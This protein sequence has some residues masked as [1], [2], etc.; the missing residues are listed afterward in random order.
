MLNFIEIRQ[1]FDPV[2][3]GI[4]SYRAMVKEYL[5]C[6]ILDFIYQS[7]YKNQLIFIGGTKLRLIDKFRRFSEDLDFDLSGD[8][9]SDDHLALCEYLVQE[10]S[11]Q[12]ITAEIDKDKKVK[13]NN[14]YTRFI[15]FP[16]VLDQIG[17]KDT[18]G[19][20]FFIKLDAQKHDFGTYSYSTETKIVNR[21]DVFTPVI[22][23]PNSMILATKLCSILER[24]KGRDFYDII[25][26]VKITQADMN[27]VSN[28]FEFGRISKKYKG[29]ETYI[30]FFNNVHKNIDWGDKVAEIEKFLFYSKESIKVK[31]F[32]EFAN[33]V[34]LREWLQG[35]E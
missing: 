2:L 22:C 11:K 19:R 30:D 27:Y 12:S 28:R 32:L 16:Q 4:T 1:Q 33:G 3:T 18:P 5:Q 35:G 10:F 7:S 9:N 8:Y 14:V 6:K 13:G 26:L 24:S 29:P 21:F 20:K 25:E 15:N 31:M 34:V 23:A 17:L